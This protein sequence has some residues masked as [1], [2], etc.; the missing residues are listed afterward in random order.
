[1]I[2]DGQQISDRVKQLARGL[3]HDIARIITFSNED[4]HV[5]TLPICKCKKTVFF[6]FFFF[7]I[8]S[9]TPGISIMECCC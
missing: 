7:F 3:H 8:S 5:S 2:G 1:M 4:L 6:F 9:V